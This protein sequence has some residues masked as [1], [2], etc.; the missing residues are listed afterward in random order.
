MLLV[1]WAV[2][3]ALGARWRLSRWTMMMTLRSCRL[4][5]AISMVALV[6][7]RLR[8]LL[9]RRQML[10]WSMLMAVCLCVRRLS[11]VLTRHSQCR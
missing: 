11:L 2:A 1:G 4:V 6:T 9:R 3:V 5:V 7:L 8:L 10:L